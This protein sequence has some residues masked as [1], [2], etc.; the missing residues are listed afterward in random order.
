MD[1]FDSYILIGGRSSRLGTDKAR[2]EI[3]GKTLLKRSIDAVREGLELS[4]ITAV[5]ANEAQF[6]IEAIAADVPFIFD[7]YEGRGPLGGLHAVLADAKTSWIFMLACDYPFVSSDL[8]ALLRE[9]VSDKF[10]C[11]VPEQ[12]DGRLQPLCAFYKVDAAKPIV[13]G[14][15][16]RPRVP[17]PMHEIVSLLTPRVVAFD[18]YSHLAGAD[19]LFANINTPDDLAIARALDL[20]SP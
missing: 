15:I 17:P 1:T 19:M 13:D 8:I 6:A 18:E 3:G 16:E 10:G 9:K 14:I 7:L 11:V 20:P 5:A 2:V 12:D 4:R